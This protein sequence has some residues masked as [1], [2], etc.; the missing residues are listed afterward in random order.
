MFYGK[1]MISN[2]KLTGALYK[3]WD[4]LTHFQLAF[5]SSCFIM[6]ILCSYWKQIRYGSSC[7]IIQPQGNTTDG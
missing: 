6:Q 1:A 2:H 3:L 5:L 4:L 7:M